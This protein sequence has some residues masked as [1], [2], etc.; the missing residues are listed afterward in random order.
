[1]HDC[2]RLA[3]EEAFR[4]P[5]F[6][7]AVC[8]RS[9]LAVAVC[10][11]PLS[12]ACAQAPQYPA[13]PSE[14]PAT[15][16]NNDALSDYSRR[17]V[18]IPMR[19]GVKLNTVILVPKAAT[20]SHPAAILLTRTPYNAALLTANAQS[21]HL[22]TSLYGYDNATDV[23]VAGG[24]IRVVQDVR[25][26]YGSEGD[27]VM[28]RPFRGPLNPTPVDHA[29]DTYDTIDW[30]IKNVPETNGKVGIIG[31]S[32][33]GF[34]SLAA[35]VHPHP[36]LK[37]AVPM[38]PMV[39]GWRGDDWFH[40][41]AFRQQNESYVYE[42]DGGRANEYR[43]PVSNYDDYAMWMRATSAGNLAK[44][45]GLEQMGFWR[46][47]IAHP[48]YDEFWQDQAVDKILGVPEP[49]AVA[50]R[51]CNRGWHDARHGALPC[52]PKRLV[53]EEC[54]G[55]VPG[56]VSE[57]RCN[58][59]TG[60]AGDRISVRC[61]RLAAPAILASGQADDEA[62]PARRWWPQLHRANGF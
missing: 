8:M 29:T 11:L 44:Q 61:Q 52:R 18:M 10:S 49:R 13:L 57:G 20:A 35:L 40:N 27:Y 54:A 53:A 39:D 43:W 60:C 17:V 38:N 50:S 14:L 58:R 41:G 34:T 1:M 37:V 30:L 51:R 62:L 4:V 3:S 7:Y 47:V 42:Q 25:G 26:K 21:T 31:I 16:V 23:I 46:K 19:D 33:D 5:R 48:T 28:N 2:G 36:A 32:Y 55:S 15:V 9:W 45:R 56:A 12:L 6:G 22:G 59:C 24:Y